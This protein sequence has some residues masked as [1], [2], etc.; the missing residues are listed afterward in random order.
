M[1]LTIFARFHASEGQEAALAA[2]LREQV[3]GVRDE[4]GC[5]AIAAYRSIRDARLY[6]IHSCWTDEAAF[7]AHAQLPRT[8]RFVART[9]ALIDQPFEATRAA[10]LG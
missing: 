6:W 2:A 9:R 8:L 5:L 3:P 4:P 10:P 7:E 1:A